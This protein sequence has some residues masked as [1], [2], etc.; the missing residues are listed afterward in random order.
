LSRPFRY[1]FI[2]GLVALATALAAVGGWRYARASA[3][4]NGPIVLISIDALRADHL[5]AY[6]YRKVQTPAID[7]LAA[8]GV[9]FEHAY[10]HVPQTLPAHAT[11]MT[12]KLPFEHGV[13]DD[14]GFTIPERERLLAEILRDRGYETA[15]VVSNIALR[16]GTG[17][18]QGFA[19]FDDG[20]PARDSDSTASAIRRDG[21]DAERAA[22]EWLAKSDAPRRFLFV[23]FDSPRAPEAPPPQF[24]RYAPYDGEIA[25]ADETVGRLLKYLKAHQLYDR[26]T[27][28]LLSDHGEGLGDHGEQEHGLFVYEEALRV[29]LIIKQA[30]GE[31]AGRRV[32]DVVQHID[33]MP[34]VLDF[35]K[36]PVPGNLRGRSLTPLLEG[37][38]SFGRRLVYSESAFGRYHFGWAV[39]QS[40]SDGRYRYIMAPAEELYDLR[41]DRAQRNPI[42][43]AKEL[44]SWRAKLKDFAPNV[45]PSSQ[46]TVSADLREQLA[47]LGAVGNPPAVADVERLADPKDKFRILEGYRAA[48][49]LAAS[50][51][52]AQAVDVLRSVVTN[53][54]DVADV[55]NRIG[56][57]KRCLVETVRRR[58]RSNASLPWSRKMRVRGCGRVGVASLAPI[59]ECA[60][61][62]RFVDRIDRTAG[63]RS[64][65]SPRASRQHRTRQTRCGRGPT[66]RRVRERARGELGI[67]Q[68]RGRTIVLRSRPLCR[69]A[70]GVRGSRR[71]VIGVRR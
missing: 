64:N 6:G 44:A 63:V 32:S 26:T 68:L 59:G 42:D 27:I 66:P 17:I 20:L 18:A 56:T 21:A 39:L 45:T 52:W 28:I 33:V 51:R 47:E 70:E 25:Q 38:G 37:T 2:M 46:T 31:G 43:D 48:T 9:V 35:A 55:W 11:L 7:Q 1:T 61:S 4:V 40:L 24:D 49:A 67:S 19:F 3:P 69:G 36:A 15:A 16:S 22:E 41:T 65:R 62:R 29:P 10:S 34:T 71:T 53:E 30:A 8:D 12:G 57:T 5:P 54:G 23:H 50:K 60:S 13:R 58:R 14:V